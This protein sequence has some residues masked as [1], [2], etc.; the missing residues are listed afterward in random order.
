MEENFH[1][2]ASKERGAD[3][4]CAFYP[5]KKKGPGAAVNGHESCRFSRAAGHFRDKALTL[6]KKI[7]MRGHCPQNTFSS[8]RK[9]LCLL[10]FDTL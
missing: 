5:D 2:T 9:R 8:L 10:N 1:A 6:M 3:R 4:D 7:L